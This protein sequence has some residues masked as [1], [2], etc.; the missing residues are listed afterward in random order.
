MIG[1]SRYK[2]LQILSVRSNQPKATE[3][4]TRLI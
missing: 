1:I 2:D 3:A 4:N